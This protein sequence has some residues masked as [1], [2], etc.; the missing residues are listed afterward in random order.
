LENKV[1]DETV[2]EENNGDMFARIAGIL[3]SGVVEDFDCT[4]WP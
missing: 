3:T 2:C 1:T 4:I